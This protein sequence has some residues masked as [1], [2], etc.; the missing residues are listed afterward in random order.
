MPGVARPASSELVARVQQG[1]WSERPD[2]QALEQH[3]EDVLHLT[4][5]EARAILYRIAA[6][7]N[8]ALFPPITKLELI[9]T[10]GCNLACTY[11]FEREMLGYRRMPLD[12]AKAGVDLLFDYSLEQPFLSISHFGGEPTL[13]FSAIQ[14]VT[15]YAEARA[16]AAGK[17]I[18]FDMTSN[19]TLINEGMARY[20]AE[21]KIMVLLSIDGLQPRHDRFRIDKHGRGT[22]AHAMRGFAL[23][24]QYQ[25]WVGV[26]MTVMPGNVADL[27]GDG[28]HG[29]TVLRLPCR[30]GQH[31]RSRNRR[32]LTMRESVG[33]QQQAARRE[34]RGRVARTHASAQP[35]RTGAL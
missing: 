28:I 19:G 30:H 31:H 7:L 13:N 1:L 5:A 24:K 18:H 14:S 9:H 10:E 23:M 34:A 4:N 3:L 22:F 33:T 15:E 17:S 20:C 8:S 6:S 29:A 21:H 16:A 2:I 35:V 32:A 12:I 11:C 27:Y 26:K 25:S